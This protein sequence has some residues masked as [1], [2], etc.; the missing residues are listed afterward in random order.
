MIR[1]IVF[2]MGNVLLMYDPLLPCRRYAA[3]EEDAR[4][5]HAAIFSTPDWL[6]LDG[7]E[8]DERELLARAQARLDTQALR[9]TAA[10]LMVDWHLDALWPK[11]GMDRVVEE[12]LSR[13]FKLYILSNAGTRFRQYQYKIPHL[14]QFSGVLVSAE[15][16][17]LKPS[18]AIFERLCQRYAL[19]PEECLF[20]DD[21]P[22]NAAGAQACGMQAYCFADG[23][24]A[25]LSATLRQLA[26]AE[27]SQRR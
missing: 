20:I 18:L 11:A 15:E 4:L 9:D 5:L 2:D 17:M 12:L 14:H 21:V 24:V 8:L 16:R 26:S 27:P 25:R 19:A 1:N 3:S 10:R 22:C 13:G 6:A 23:D 7:G